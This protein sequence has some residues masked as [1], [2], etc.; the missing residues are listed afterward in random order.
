M[1][2][3]T[4]GHCVQPVLIYAQSVGLV[5]LPFEYIMVVSIIVYGIITISVLIMIVDFVKSTA[6]IEYRIKLR[7][8]E[9]Q[10]QGTKYNIYTIS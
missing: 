10:T 8:S 6:I 2:L 7:H 1:I 4:V 3:C 5:D 9:T